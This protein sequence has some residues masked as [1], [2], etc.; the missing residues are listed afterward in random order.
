MKCKCWSNCHQRVVQ[1]GI[2][3][4]LQLYKTQ[5]KGNPAVFSQYGEMAQS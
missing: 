1:H 2:T 4:G 5:D 3:A